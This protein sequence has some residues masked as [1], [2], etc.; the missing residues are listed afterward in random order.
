LFSIDWQLV[1]ELIGV[2]TDLVDF[3]DLVLC[4]VCGGFI[5]TMQKY[6][7][8][9]NKTLRCSLFEEWGLFLQTK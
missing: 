9:T 6:K 4:N 1:K 3:A 2:L 7:Q 5:L 8:A